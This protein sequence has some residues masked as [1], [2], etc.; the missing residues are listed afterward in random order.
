MGYA[1]M[2]MRQ[3]S[4][5][6]V[7]EARAGNYFQHL[8]HFTRAPFMKLQH[9][10]VPEGRMGSRL[11]H[12]MGVALKCMLM[13]SLGITRQDLLLECIALHPQLSILRVASPAHGTELLEASVVRLLSAQLKQESLGVAYAK[14][15]S[16]NGSSQGMV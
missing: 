8:M 12:L 14:D 16:D 7:P 10:Q 3:M 4:L 6:H 15:I 5:S 9:S 1:L 2:V 11:W 13:R